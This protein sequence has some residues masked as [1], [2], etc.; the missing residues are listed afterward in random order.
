M[1]LIAMTYASVQQQFLGNVEA[2]LQQAEAAIQLA[3]RY[4]F[5]LWLSMAK[6]LRGW[7][8]T[9]LNAFDAG[10]AE[11]QESITLFRSTG[12][13]LGAAYFAGL[14]AETLV[15]NHQPDLGL[16]ALGEA[17]DLLERAQ[18]R[19]CEAELY[20]IKALVFQHYA[21]RIEDESLAEE[22]HVALEMAQQVA[23]AQGA[24]QWAARLTSV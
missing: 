23:E 17:F 21:A 12:A 3:E 15:L 6:F 16:L 7:S 18:D 11:M 8:H 13:E 14:L 10:F 9:R 24:Q 1:L 2:C 4:G 5:T 20:R 19:W 22:V